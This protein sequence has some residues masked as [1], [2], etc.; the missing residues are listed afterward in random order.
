M[1]DSPYLRALETSVHGAGLPYGYAVTVWSTGAA[2]SGK[3]GMPSVGTIFLF[4]AGATIAYGALRLLTWNT[5]E[6]ADMPLARSPH[7]IRAGVIHLAAIALA[8]TAAVLMARVHGDAAWTLA[9]LAATL[10]YLGV[11]SV[12][13]AL[14]EDSRW[15][16][17]AEG[18]S[19]MRTRERAFRR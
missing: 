9:P 5:H 1:L 6:E 10:V 11:S 8:V 14:V 18:T 3:H 7:V 12:E 2:L 4:A 16:S 17:E 13:V 19:S 15:R